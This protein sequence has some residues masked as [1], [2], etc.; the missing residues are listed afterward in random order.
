MIL[1]G[2][3]AAV[4][5]IGGVPSAGAKVIV[6]AAPLVLGIFALIVSAVPVAKKWKS[7]GYTVVGLVSLLACLASLAV[8]FELGVGLAVGAMAGALILFFAAGVP[9]IGKLADQS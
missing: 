8:E 7:A 2:L 5:I 9:L 6:L 1:M 4:A 3:T